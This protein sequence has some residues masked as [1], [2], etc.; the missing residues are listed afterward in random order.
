MVEVETPGTE[1]TKPGGGSLQSGEGE[2]LLDDKTVAVDGILGLGDVGPSPVDEGEGVELVTTVGNELETLGGNE[3][4]VGGNEGVTGGIEG[5]TVVEESDEDEGGGDGATDGEGAT[6]SGIAQ[7][8][9]S[10]CPFTLG[11]WGR[12]PDGPESWSFLASRLNG[13]PESTRALDGRRI[14]IVPGGSPSHTRKG[15]VEWGWGSQS[16][17]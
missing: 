11:L 5:V 9:K 10:S 17:K 13:L 8:G 3:E 12:L 16:G 2:V 6:R 7:G 4:G 15:E 14:I 1:T